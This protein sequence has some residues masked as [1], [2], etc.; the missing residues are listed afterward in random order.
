MRRTP[1]GCGR[2]SAEEGEPMNVRR[3]GPR[4]RGAGACR[5]ARPSAAANAT[6]ISDYS[7]WSASSACAVGDG[8]MIG[9]CRR[10]RGTATGRSCSTTSATVEDWTLNGPILDGDQLRHRPARTDKRLIRQRRTADQQ[11][12]IFRSNMTAARNRGDAREPLPGARRG[13]RLQ[14]RSRC[15]RGRSSAP[16][17]SSSITSISTTTSCGARAA[18]SAR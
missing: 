4:C 3:T 18:R 15:S 12:P 5:P 10:G 14:D 11:V 8:S 13:G 2:W 16:T 7:G 9:C 1:P 17:A 6:A